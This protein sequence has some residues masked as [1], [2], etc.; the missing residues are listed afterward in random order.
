MLRFSDQELNHFFRG[1]RRA[2][3]SKVEYG[4]RKILDLPIADLT[5]RKVPAEALAS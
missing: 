2:G 1:A 3:L 4:R 5:E